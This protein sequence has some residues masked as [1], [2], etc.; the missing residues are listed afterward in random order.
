MVADL[1]PSICWTTLTS[2]PA[3]IASEAA[4]WRSACGVRQSRPTEAA[5]S[6][7][8]A[9]WKVRD[10][11]GAPVSRRRTPARHRPSRRHGPQ[12]HRRGIEALE[13]RGAR[14]SWDRPPR[15]GHPRR[16][17]SR[18]WT[19]GAASGRGHRRSPANSPHRKPV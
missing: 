4:V 7:N 18:Q 13:P 10:R 15:H 19:H 5:A 12:A 6:L 2:A 9:R 14:G 11:M 8:T 16:H 17:T 3:A 1:C